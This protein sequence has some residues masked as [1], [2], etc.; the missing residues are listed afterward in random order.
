MKMRVA[1]VLLVAAGAV[2]SGCAAHPQYIVAGPL[3]P[4]I[5]AR[6]PLVETA[7]HNG[8]T[9]GMRDGHRDRYENHSY[10]PEH[11]DRF[12]DTPGYF[13]ELGGSK[14]VYRSYYRDAYLRGYHNAYTRG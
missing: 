8:Y 7:E 11:S 4:A 1:G 12:E 5:D 13:R 2:L 6:Q 14:D 9:D 10:R 3:P